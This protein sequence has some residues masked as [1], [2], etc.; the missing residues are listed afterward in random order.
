MNIQFITYFGKEKLITTQEV[1]YSRFS[2]PCSFSEFDLNII[3]LQDETIWR[4]KDYSSNYHQVDCS[5]HLKSLNGQIKTSTKNTIVF[6][7]QNCIF[8]YGSE[9][10]YSAELKDILQ[11]LL[12]STLGNSLLNLNGRTFSLLFENC[13]TIINGKE[14]I[15]AFV[16]DTYGDALTKSKSNNSITTFK[17]NKNCIL[18]SLDLTELN[19][20]D[21]L[22]E[23]GLLKIVSSI[24]DWIHDITF[25]NDKD[26]ME[27]KETK[28]S[29]IEQ[30]KTAISNIDDQLNNNAFYKKL[31]YT[32]GDEL[33]EVVFNVLEQILECDMSEFED[34]KKE[35]FLIK[36]GNVTFIGEIKGVSTNVKSE[37]ISQLDVHYQSYLDKLAEESITENV[38][39]LLII[40]PFKNKPLNERDEIHENQI[41]L[42]KRNESLIITTETLLKVY[43]E[44][45]SGK[46]TQLEIMN[47]FR[48]QK[49][50]YKIIKSK[51]KETADNSAYKI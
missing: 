50:L 3:S 32:N 36:L 27:E 11:T 51:A 44:F 9:Y 7:P 17:Y 42:A 47:S 39:A 28:S 45:L 31:L 21:F 13:N 40:N 48:S 46:K 37:H 8:K 22:S 34:E 16:F 5:N 10:K 1:T 25:Y 26:L 19:I 2:N 18:S 4:N 33:V 29:E 12:V 30:I 35:D 15:S 49:G 38:K 20:D 24:P 43:E 23:I 6:L 14:V 41:K